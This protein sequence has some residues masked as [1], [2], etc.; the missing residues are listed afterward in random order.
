MIE[1]FEEFILRMHLRYTI[2]SPKHCHHDTQTEP[3]LDSMGH[4]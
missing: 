4:V 1:T 3:A 2:A